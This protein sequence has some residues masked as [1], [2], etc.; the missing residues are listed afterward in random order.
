[1]FQLDVPACPGKPRGTISRITFCRSGSRKYEAGPTG[2]PNDKADVDW[3]SY[4]E[5]QL[6]YT[7]PA[8][9]DG[10]GHGLVAHGVLTC[11]FPEAPKSAAGKTRSASGLTRLGVRGEA[12]L[13][14]STGAGGGVADGAVGRTLLTRIDVWPP[15]KR[16]KSHF[17][18]QEECMRSE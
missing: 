5:S 17:S 10:D 7:L 1:V 6:H 18:E 14:R 12:V 11:A 13:P 2:A 4:G 15:S 9:V 8:P 3:R 16:K